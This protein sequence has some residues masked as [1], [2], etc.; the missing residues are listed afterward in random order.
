MIKLKLKGVKSFRANVPLCGAEPGFKPRPVYMRNPCSL[1]SLPFPPNAVRKSPAL[2][3]KNKKVHATH[4]HTHTHTHTKSLQEKDD[5]FNISAFQ[6]K[7][8]F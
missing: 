4:T 6:S 2:T 1:P 3:E 5:T 8:S 7:I